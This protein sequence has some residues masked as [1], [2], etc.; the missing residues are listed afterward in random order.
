[1]CLG[2][3]GCRC[4]MDLTDEAETRLSWQAC[5]R[6]SARALGVDAASVC[7]G[8]IVVDEAVPKG[9]H[10]MPRDCGVGVLH[11]LRDTVRS[12]ADDDEV[13]SDRLQRPLILAQ[14][15]QGHAARE[16][17][18]LVYGIE[19]LSHPLTPAFTG[20]RSAPPAPSIADEV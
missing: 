12:F 20:H 17:L 9:P 4:D 16:I 5:L 3:R 18:D 11:A 13:H 8:E 6:A 7:E 14:S 19:D 15:L 10:Q 2:S 1:M